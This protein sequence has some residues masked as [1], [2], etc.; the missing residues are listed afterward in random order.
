MWCFLG[1][2]GY[3]NNHDF[4]TNRQISQTSA[5]VGHEAVRF[6]RWIAT[7][8]LLHWR[9]LLHVGTDSPRN[10]H[11]DVFKH[12]KSN[13]HTRNSQSTMRVFFAKNIQNIIERQICSWM[14]TRTLSFLISFS[15][16]PKPDIS[17]IC[18]IVISVH[19]LALSGWTPNGQFLL[20]SLVFKCCF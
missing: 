13:K 17:C 15:S 14:C 2:L 10:C 20:N 12:N 11:L 3:R 18:D 6:W 9:R 5:R 4:W 8:R 19:Y 7:A 16:H 1:S